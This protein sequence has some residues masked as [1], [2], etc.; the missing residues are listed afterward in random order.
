[1]LRTQLIRA[2]GGRL[3]TRQHLLR[4][5][6]SVSIPNAI[7]VSVVSNAKK[8]T[9]LARLDASSRDCRGGPVVGELVRRMAR[10]DRVL[11]ADIGLR[12]CRWVAPILLAQGVYDERVLAASN[13]SLWCAGG[14]WQPAVLGRATPRSSPQIR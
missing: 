13:A 12:S 11:R 1:M 7:P 5:F 8:L 9:L 14:T 3:P 4:V 6:S 2:V 10:R